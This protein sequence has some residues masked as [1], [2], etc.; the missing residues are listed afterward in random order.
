MRSG[1]GMPPGALGTAGMD[2]LEEDL[3]GAD[4]HFGRTQSLCCQE[5]SY[6]VGSLV[7]SPSLTA[8]HVKAKTWCYS[9]ISGKCRVPLLVTVPVGLL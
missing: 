2:A 3:G 7:P 6:G 9:A 5:A 1:F 8:V 4:T